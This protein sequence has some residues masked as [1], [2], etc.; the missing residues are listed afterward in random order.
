MEFR[1]IEKGIYV[2][3]DSTNI[4]VIETDKGI[5]LIDAGIDKDKGKKIK[6]I[7]EEAGINPKYLLLSHHHADHTG[8]AKFLKEYFG[9]SLISSKEEKVFIENPMLE[10]IYLSQGAKPINQFLNK[11]ILS[12]PVTIDYTTSEINFKDLDFLD[13]SGHS[14]GMV[15]VRVG[16]F[17][18]AGDGFFSEEVL[19]KYKVPYFHD[20]EKFRERM[21]FLKEM[22]FKYIVP[23][24]GGIYTKEEADKI[25]ELNIEIL[26]KMENNVLDL[27]KEEKSMEGIIE[28][29]KILH[30]DIIVYTLIE[31]SVKSLLNSLIERELVIYEVKDGKLRY[32]KINKSI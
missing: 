14:M 32:K 12:S 23:S 17:V 16:D 15:G 20:F 26:N 18:F 8:G 30:Q 6:K 7:L 11:W 1:E 4:P 31:S 10:P 13:L 28:G 29:L 22:N 5:L 27:L 3:L 24:H 2:I 19:E 25:I 21:K 9:L